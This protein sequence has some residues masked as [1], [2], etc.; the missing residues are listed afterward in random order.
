MSNLKTTCLFCNRN[1]ASLIDKTKNLYCCYGCSSTFYIE[2]K[3]TNN[4][5]SKLT[6]FES[7]LHKMSFNIPMIDGE[8][9]Y[10]CIPN[11]RGNILSSFYQQN[12][13]KG[14]TYEERENILFIYRKYIAY[15]QKNNV[16]EHSSSIKVILHNILNLDITDKQ[17]SIRTTQYPGRDASIKAQLPLWYQFSKT[18]KNKKAIFRPMDISLKFD[19]EQLANDFANITYSGQ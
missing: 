19:W 9:D 2:R 18:I 16:T 15:L 10:S 8:L 13:G 7:L 12:K 14:F 6:Y 1:T 17:F 4:L 11:Q 5:Q 3:N